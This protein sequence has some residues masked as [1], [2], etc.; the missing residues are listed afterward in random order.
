[1]DGDDMTLWNEENPPRRIR[2][3]WWGWLITFVIGLAV[4]LLTYQWGKPKP[5][6]FK[7]PKPELHVSKAP[8]EWNDYLPKEKIESEPDTKLTPEESTVTAA[9]P[10]EPAPEVSEPNIPASDDIAGQAAQDTAP[11]PEEDEQT[12]IEEEPS[13]ST[14]PAGEDIAELKEEL[15]TLEERVTALETEKQQ[16][17]KT[18]PIY[19]RLYRLQLKM[20]KGERVDE[21]LATLKDL[22]LDEDQQS[23]VTMLEDLN[24]QGVPAR[25]VLARAFSARADQFANTPDSDKGALSE[26]ESW[27]KKQI[28][29]R[30]V[31]DTHT[32]NDD[33]SIIAR[34]EAEV[35]AGKLKE[36]LVETDGLSSRAQRFFAEWR[37]QAERRLQTDSLLQQLEQS[38]ATMSRVTP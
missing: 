14:V 15:R 6:S 22:P 37:A 35:K 9:P 18:A 36:A 2:I 24:R 1:M 34:A 31:G 10:A 7:E 11:A 27:L 21:I 12:P 3:A 32:G 25:S 5:L 29:I 17:A 33:E 26:A 8:R 19:E 28:V 30:K 4:A 23:L 20:E 16:V 38:L 13:A